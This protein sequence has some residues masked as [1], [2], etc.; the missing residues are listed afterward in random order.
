MDLY[1]IEM[2][3]EVSSLLLCIFELCALNIQVHISGCLLFGV[4]SVPPYVDRL[5]NYNNVPCMP[6]G[7]RQL[8]NGVP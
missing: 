4:T 5:D 6:N 7:E 2:L 8:I 1:L 3:Q